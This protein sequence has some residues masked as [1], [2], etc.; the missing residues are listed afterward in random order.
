MRT[1]SVML[2]LLLVVST[3]PAQVSAQDSQSTPPRRQ[4]QTQA[5]APAPATAV[6]ATTLIVPAGTQIPVTLSS[7][8]SSKSAKPGKTVRVSTA[9]PVTVGSLVAIPVGTYLEGVIDKVT[10]S[11]SGTT[12]QMHFTRVIF[13]N[14][15]TVDVDATNQSARVAKPDSGS[16]MPASFTAGSRDGNGAPHLVLVA[17]QLPT[18]PALPHNGP[19]VGTAIGIGVGLAVVAIVATILAVRHGAGARNGVLFDAGW[20]FDV[21]LQNPLTLNAASVAARASGP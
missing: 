15:Y 19:G 2:A 13:A 6:P 12:L 18:P 14:G 20:Q 11:H 10:K 8:I 21:V 4:S 5:L 16:F 1:F 3:C 9:F 7:P 17:Q